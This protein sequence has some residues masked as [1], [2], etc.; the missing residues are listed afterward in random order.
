MNPNPSVNSSD[1]MI[2]VSQPGLYMCKRSRK[3]ESM[4]LSGKSSKKL[5]CL[6]MCSTDLLVFPRNDIDAS[7]PMTS[8]PREKD[9][10]AM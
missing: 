5:E 9:L 6:S 3:A 1:R 4:Y 10:L 7:A 8:T 2:L